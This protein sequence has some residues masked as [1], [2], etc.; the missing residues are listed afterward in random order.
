MRSFLRFAAVVGA[1][2][3]GAV[4]AAPAL[5]ATDNQ[6]GANAVFVS[7]A[8][9]G[10]G[11]GNVTASYSDGKETTAGNSQ[12]AFPDPTGQ[13]FITGGV[14]AQEATAKPGFTAACAGLA[15]DGGSVIKIGDSSCL[16]PGNIVSGSFGSFDPSTLIPDSSSIPT[17]EL[18]QQAQDLLTQ[19]NQ[20]AEP[21]DNA[22]NDALSQAQEQFGEGGLVA[23]LDAVEGRCTAGDGGPTGTSTLTDASLTFNIPGQDPINL[24]TL[25]VHPKPNTHVFTNLSDVMNAILDGVDADLTDSLQGN[26]SPLKELT[27]QVRSQIVTQVH[28]QLEANL[29]P[30][31]DN[32]LDIT[33]NQ[34]VHPTADSI[35]VRALDVQVLPAA[36]SQL[37]GN[38][39]VNLQ[40]GNA[41]C[42]PVARVAAVD[43]PQAAPAKSLPT[44]VSAGLATAPDTDSHTGFVLAALAM[45]AVGGT[46]LVVIRWL[47]A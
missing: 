42:A 25:P 30:L 36:K 14:L 27:A 22:I 46:A 10:Q 33:L 11:S 1:L 8:G 40:I 3:V 17:G 7:V 47:R 21:L 31:E 28:E 41:A 2:T 24:V 43:A 15:G 13:K 39:L 6:A 20:G 23:N 12:P 29:K 4:A 18:P 9:N 19:L 45:M 16:E 32:L 26:A 37:D 44:A 38:S 35:K 34:Q 5:A